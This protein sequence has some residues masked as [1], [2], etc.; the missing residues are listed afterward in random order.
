MVM[1]QIDRITYTI[2]RTL[3]S[4]VLNDDDADDLLS[5]SDT[6]IN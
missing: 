4:V 2:D 6:V 1:R 5:A 3:P